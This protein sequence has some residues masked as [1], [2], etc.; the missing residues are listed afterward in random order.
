[1]SYFA[2]TKADA[3]TGS[4]QRESRPSAVVPLTGLS[5][6]L[7]RRNAVLDITDAIART[8]TDSK[9]VVDLMVRRVSEVLDGCAF[10]SLIAGD[11]RTLDVVA[12]YD[13]HPERMAVVRSSLEAAP[14]DAQK[15]LTAQALATGKPVLVQRASSCE[16]RLL[17]RP[18]RGP[19]LDRLEV[20]NVLIA[21]VSARGFN[22]GTLVV[23]GTDPRREFTTD[24]GQFLLEVA[25]LG[26]HAILSTYLFTGFVREVIARHETETRLRETEEQYRLIFEN[27]PEGLVMADPKTRRF[28]SANRAFLQMIGASREE[29]PGLGVE[30]IHPPESLPQVI[31]QFDLIAAGQLTSALDVP[32]KRRSGDVF[33]V[34]I[35]A[36]TVP[37]GG[38]TQLVAVFRDNTERK[39]TD[40]ALEENARRLSAL[41]RRLIEV[42]EE[43]RRRLA[44]ELHD[45]LGQT[46]TILNGTLDLC[47]SRP[48]EQTEQLL[49]DARAITKDLMRMV[50]SMA[51]DLRPA[52]LDHLGLMAALNWCAERLTR[53]SGIKVDV[54][55]GD[56]EGRRYPRPVETAAYRVV[57]EAL[58]NVARHAKVESAV[59]R[60]WEN[61]SGLF[62]QIADGG[63]GFKFPQGHLG[64]TSLGLTCMEERVKAAGGTLSIETEPGAG[65]YVTAFFPIAAPDK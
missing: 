49:Q 12:C 50:R 21:P 2:G 25:S 63:C 15:G 34:D 53:L 17:L 10:L 31:H 52:M 40:S 43:E 42:Q 57:Q 3:K 64:K 54:Q 24:D 58:T 26:A 11:G 41:A 27:S 4:T 46:L 39:T 47:L 36:Y 65:T 20:L 6:S 30:D 7:D 51:L 35:T 38:K 37:C 44:A 14:Q 62:V 33:H 13:T 48:R 23:M 29:I 60:V 9:W 22:L 8:R 59:V 45:E 5:D 18:E 55:Y 28:L 19:L 61:K 16:M 32:V 1:M 56:M